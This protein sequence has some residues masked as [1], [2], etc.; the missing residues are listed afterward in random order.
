L[1]RRATVGSIC[2][3]GTLSAE[4]VELVRS[5]QPA[6]DIDLAALVSDDDVARLWRERAEHLFDPSV[7]VSFRF[8]GMAPV[9]YLEL[10]GLRSAWRDW[11]RR[12]VS[13]RV[14]IDDLIDAGDRVVVMHSDYAQREPGTR[15]VVRQR[16]AV[17]TIRDGC[18]THVDFY[19][20][21]AEALTAVGLA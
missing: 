11:L 10:P 7:E 14:D 9:T 1:R 15:E 16:A 4:N 13:Y 20:R 3:A 6:S 8:P 2:G 5:L 21:R 19:L 18:V 12:W 17:W